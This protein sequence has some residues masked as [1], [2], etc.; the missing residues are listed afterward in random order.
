MAC[1]PLELIVT[2]LGF[3]GYPSITIRSIQASVSNLAV[4]SRDLKNRK[5]GI[6]NCDYGEIIL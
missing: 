4:E 6:I 5:I 2:R 1:L 3:F